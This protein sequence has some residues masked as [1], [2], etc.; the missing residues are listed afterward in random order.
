MSNLVNDP[1]LQNLKMDLRAKLIEKMI[2]AG[3]KAPFI[4]EI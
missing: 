2:E 3:E 4:E 1:D